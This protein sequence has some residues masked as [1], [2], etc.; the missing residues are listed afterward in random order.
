MTDVTL[1]RLFRFQDDAAAHN[2]GRSPQVARLLEFVGDSVRI[3][4]HSLACM[5]F[6]APKQHT[7]RVL[8]LDAVTGIV[9]SVRVGLW[10]NLPEAAALL[11]CGLEA[12]A[13]LSATVQANGFET[14]AQEIQEARLKRH[15]FRRS[16]EALGELG[17]RIDYLWGRLS[18]LGAHST[19]TRLKFES[20]TLNGERF[21]RLAAAYD[22]EA[23]ELALSMVPDVC[24]HLLETLEMAYAQ[25][26]IEF[27]GEAPLIGLRTRFAE[28][29]KNSDAGPA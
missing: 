27:P 24:L 11:R 14:T 29:K 19:G 25:E 10:G 16:A 4:A 9:T 2:I 20:Y 13:I 6:S 12:A 18:D 23:A 3:L 17:R 5:R 15:S 8:G 1:E 28:C 26:G 7:I 22:P 21:D